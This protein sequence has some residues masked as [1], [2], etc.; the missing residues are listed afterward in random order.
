MIDDDW[1]ATQISVGWEQYDPKAQEDFSIHF[2]GMQI[3]AC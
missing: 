1:P 3:C 2:N